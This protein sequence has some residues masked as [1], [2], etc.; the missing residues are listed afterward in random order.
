LSPSDAVSVDFHTNYINFAILEQ[1]M[2]W[3]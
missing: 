2:M 3:N 1:Q